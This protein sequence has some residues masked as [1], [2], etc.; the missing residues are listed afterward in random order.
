M[1]DGPVNPGA[2][3][4]YGLDPSLQTDYESLRLDLVRSRWDAKAGRWDRDLA[5]PSCHLHEDD[6]Y[7]RFLQIVSPIVVKRAAF[8]RRRLLVDLGCGT[9]LVLAHCIESFAQGLGIDLSPRMVEA[10]RQKQLPRARFEVGNAFDLSRSVSR[11]GAIVSRGVLLSHYGRRWTPA[12]LRE[13]HRSLAPDCGFAVLDF[14]NAAARH[15]YP[16]NPDNKT[17]FSAGE[18]QSLA[19]QAGFRRCFCFGEPQRRSLVALLE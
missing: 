12:L 4:L 7:R 8:C 16:S 6:A 15:R 11:A 5:D 9:G 13:V 14:L 18:V 1:E 17:F 2:K 19:L 3:D 10:A